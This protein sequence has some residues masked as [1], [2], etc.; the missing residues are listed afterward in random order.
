MHKYLTSSVLALLL[1]VFVMPYAQGASIDLQV[2]TGQ[3]PSDRI[4]TCPDTVLSDIDVQVTNLGGRTDTIKLS[5]DWPADLGFIQ[6]FRTLASGETSFIYPFWLTVPYTMEPGI[7]HARITA[8]S[9]M[10]GDKITKDIEIEVLKCHSVDL[11]V[12]DGQ[13]NVCAESGEPATF[14]VDLI[15]NGKFDET[16]L[17]S[18]SVDWADLSKDRVTVGTGRTETVSLVVDPPAGMARGKHTIYITARSVESYAT[19]TV[20]VEISIT[21]C[22]SFDA[23]L[24]PESQS[25]CIQEPKTFDLIITNTGDLEDE[26][27]ITAPDWI[28]SQYD[29][30]VIRGKESQAIELTALPEELGLHTFEVSV[31]SVRDKDAD[32]LILKGAINSDECRAVAVILDPDEK[33][34]CIGD[35]AKFS[36][37]IKNTGTQ[38]GTFALETTFGELEADEIEL[39]AGDSKTIIL[40]VDTSDLPEGTV[41]TD[42]TASDGPISDTSSVELKV[43][44]CFLAELTTQ[45]D[46][47]TVC[48]GARIP[49]TIKVKNTGKQTDE[50]QLEFGD[51]KTNVTLSPG[52]THTISYDYTLPEVDEGSYIFEVKLKSKGGIVMT[53]ESSVTVKASEVC[54]G[55]EL[56]D[57][58]GIVEVGKATT[59]EVTI[60]NTGEQSD[61]FL[62]TALEAPEWVFIEPTEVH[63]GGKEEGFIYIYASPGFSTPMGQYTVKLNAASEHA[64]DELTVLITVPENI[65]AV[66]PTT[67]GGNISINVTHPSDNGSGSITGGVVEERPFW[68][69]AAVALIALIIVAILVLR[70]VL[71]LKK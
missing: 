22:F 26:F 52:D 29:K 62:V 71:L 5:L 14:S 3:Q 64:S 28:M 70:F 17:V 13:A 7:Y 55:V 50:Y 46:N 2:S 66:P 4:A 25:A 6:P 49:Y 67:P 65:T 54:Y 1:M 60:R 31:K 8:E 11:A 10:T 38:K 51:K 47:V 42:V 40:T 21:D 58:P 44:T 41:V 9:S 36:V 48:P 24:E 23:R 20:P 16:F 69:T 32:R 57:D 56:I 33:T 27:E 35:E 59:V 19:K 37:N 68:K 18:A 61:T 12:E 34:A 45:P 39:A 30:V 15:N 63:L 43:D 53:S